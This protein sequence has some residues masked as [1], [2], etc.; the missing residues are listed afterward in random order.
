MDNRYLPNDLGMQSLLNSIG[1]DY[2]DQP[3]IDANGY[4][5][6]Y[7][8][9]P[10]EWVNGYPYTCYTSTQSLPNQTSVHTGTGINSKRMRVTHLL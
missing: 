8:F 10:D 6:Q 7:D 5:L 9:M 3:R 4:N 2:S 1:V